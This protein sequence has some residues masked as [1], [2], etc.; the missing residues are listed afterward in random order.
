MEVSRDKLKDLGLDYGTGS[1]GSTARAL[2]HQGGIVTSQLL[3]QGSSLA[4]KPAGF[5]PV[6]SAIKGASPFNLG[7]DLL[8]QKL[9]G[10][11]FQ[12]MLHALE[13]DVHTN[14]L[15]CP[16]IMALNNQ[17]ATILVGTRYPIL[18][19]DTTSSSSSATVTTVSLDYY[20]DIGIQL[21][22]VPQVGSDDHIN[23]VV[24]PAVTSFT[25]TLGGPTDIAQF[26]VIDVREAETRILIKD[27]ETVVIGGLLKDIK[28]KNRQGIPFLSKIPLLGVL[29]SR[30]TVDLGKVDML[31][32]IK[33]HIVKDGEL[34][35]QNLA[36]L[37]KR[38]E[39]AAEKPVAKKKKK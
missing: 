31:I 15:S 13:E 20:Q 4:V 34:T 14:T 26:P 6:A 11:Q 16:Q 36:L 33:A 2:T 5:S 17:E 10:N 30:D 27:G 35:E 39:K 19:Q 8:Y 24:H 9:T 23:L 18:K 22:V 38:L 21:N 37:E 7:L 3:G 28:T 12:V 25:Q 1:D 32:F 29:F